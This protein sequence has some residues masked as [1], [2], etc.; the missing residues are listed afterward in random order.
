MRALLAG[1]TLPGFDPGD[2]AYVL[3][4]YTVGFV[5]EE[6]AYLGLVD[7]GEWDELIRNPPPISITIPTRQGSDAIGILGD[8][9]D[10]RFRTGLKTVLTGT[11]AEAPYV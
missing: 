3:R 9:R 8:D 5:I 10:Q 1:V 7:S 2:I 6:Q 4:N 11:V